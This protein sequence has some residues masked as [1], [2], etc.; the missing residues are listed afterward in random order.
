MNTK[1]KISI[2]L[3]ALFLVIFSCETTDLDVNENPNSATPESAD[4]DL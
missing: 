2:V 1:N 3:F 4:V